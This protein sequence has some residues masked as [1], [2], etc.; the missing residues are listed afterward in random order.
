MREK[1]GFPNLG[2]LSVLTRSLERRRAGASNR[3]PFVPTLGALPFTAL[4]GI[5]FQ[6]H[7]KPSGFKLHAVIHSKPVH[8]SFS[9]RSLSFEL[10]AR[11]IELE[12][13]SQRSFRGLNSGRPAKPSSSR[14]R[15]WLDL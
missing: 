15:R 13:L 5:E 14:P 7:P 9:L 6:L 12:M 4:V 8:C 1:A 3:S 2:Q 11:R 10:E